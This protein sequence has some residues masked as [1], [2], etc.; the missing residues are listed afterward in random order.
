MRTRMLTMVAAL[1]VLTPAA[2]WAQCQVLDD[3]TSGPV[4]LIL[5]VPNSSTRHVETGTMI[6]GARLNVFRLGP[7]QFLQAGELDA[8]VSGPYVLTMGVREFFRVDLAY[9]VTAAGTLNLL[10]YHPAGCD[11]F[12]V[13]FNAASQVLNFNVEPFQAPGFTPFLNGINLN[14]VSAAGNP[15]CADFLFTHFVTNAPGITQDFAGK[16]I[17]FIDFIFQSGSANGANAFALTR[18]ETTDLATAT[19]NPCMFVAP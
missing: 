5:R 7:N 4:R 19:A 1:L 2:A 11:R 14:P 16:G 12:R 13:S 9:G 18:I 15:F 8:D 6:G 3:F 17:D 10:G